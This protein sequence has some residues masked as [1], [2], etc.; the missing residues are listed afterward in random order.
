MRCAVRCV[1]GFTV[2]PGLVLKREE[3][4]IGKSTQIGS[5]TELI[6]QQKTM[7]PIDGVSYF[8]VRRR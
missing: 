4:D 3:R 8:P 7:K 5:V 1:F 2:C 6:N